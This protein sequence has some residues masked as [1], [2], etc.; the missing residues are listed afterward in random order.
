MKKF[1]LIVVL[2][3]LFFGFKTFAGHT[4]TTTPRV[5]GN[6]DPNTVVH[7]WGLNNFQTPKVS[8]GMS[9]M[10]EHNVKQECPKF[11]KV[12]LDITKTDYYRQKMTKMTQMILDKYGLNA[13]Q[14]F[15]HLKGWYD[16]VR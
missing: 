8:S 10:D 16:F 13:Y 9:V 2:F 3:G 6:G 5:M 11:I 4:S 12:C 14:I 1:I 7:A 15:P